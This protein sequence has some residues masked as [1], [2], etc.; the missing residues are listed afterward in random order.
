MLDKFAHLKDKLAGSYNF[1]C[2]RVGTSVCKRKQFKPPSKV[3]CRQLAQ[4]NPSVAVQLKRSFACFVVGSFAEVHLQAD[5]YGI[6]APLLELIRNAR[7]NL[8]QMTVT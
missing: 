1:N 8:C 7:F 2:N 5:Y 6:G 3:Q 4:I